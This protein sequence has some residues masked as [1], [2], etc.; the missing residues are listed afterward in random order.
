MQVRQACT[1]SSAMSTIQS[2]PGRS[3]TIPRGT[4][5]SQRVWLEKINDAA[6]DLLNVR[7]KVLSVDDALAAALGGD[8]DSN[9]EESIGTS[10]SDQDSDDAEKLEDKQAAPL[11][12]RCSRPSGTSTGSGGGGGGGGKPP[13]VGGGGG[14]GN[15]PSGGGTG[16]GG[17][18]SSTTDSGGGD[19]G[20]GGG[21]G[22]STRSKDKG[23]S[24]TPPHLDA[25]IGAADGRAERF[26][27][28]TKS[29]LGDLE[30]KMEDVKELL[31]VDTE[32]F[33]GNGEKFRKDLV[34]SK[35]ECDRDRESCCEHQQENQSDRSADRV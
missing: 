5:L 20:G 22:G 24:K 19:G 35:K 30:G 16:G 3:S 32:Q 6:F 15:R 29:Q 21:G 4:A 31:F 26:K 28:T 11:F 12:R 23:G 13:K 8:A 25:D 34:N 14:G 2:R 18:R 7:G 9:E 17:V 33:L 1:N 27:K 10:D